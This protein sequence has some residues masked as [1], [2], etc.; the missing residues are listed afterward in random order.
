MKTHRREAVNPHGVDALRRR[1]CSAVDDTPESPVG[2]G[3]HSA[4][5]A[6]ENVKDEN[7]SSLGWVRGPRKRSGLAASPPRG[8]GRG[9]DVYMPWCR[10]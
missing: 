8:A 6:C 5:A 2:L 3:M 4:M 1:W 10:C 7:A 9:G